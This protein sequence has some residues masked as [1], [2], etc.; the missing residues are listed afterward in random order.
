MLL[1]V[2]S[3]G[4]EGPGPRVR[5]VRVPERGSFKGFVTR[6][7]SFYQSSKGSL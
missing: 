7:L 3:V 5:G 2:L 6:S 4:R 1:P